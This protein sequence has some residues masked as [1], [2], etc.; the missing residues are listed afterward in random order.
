[1]EQIENSGNQETDFQF[2]KKKGWLY[3][4]YEKD[5]FKFHRKSE[6]ILDEH[7]KWKDIVSYRFE[8]KNQSRSKSSGSKSSTKWEDLSKAFEKWLDS[9]AK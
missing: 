4:Y 7:L 9:L 2:I 1:M 6:K 5:Y 3:I 8:S